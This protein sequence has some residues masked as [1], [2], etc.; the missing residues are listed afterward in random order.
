MKNDDDSLTHT[1]WRCQY[2]IVITPKHRR[3]I[4]Y[5][6]YVYAAYRASGHSRSFA[7]AH[8]QALALCKASKA[9]F[10]E[11]GLQKLP[12]I[13]MLRSECAELIEQKKQAYRQARDE[14]R[15]LLRTK[16]NVELI[17]EM[18]K[19]HRHDP[20]QKNQTR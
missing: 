10:D 2:H 20:K 4:I 8:K 3:Q 5:G 15:D 7:T 12:T 19:V 11:L 18:D 13:K 6:R 14:M 16:A 9:A 17:L 1:K